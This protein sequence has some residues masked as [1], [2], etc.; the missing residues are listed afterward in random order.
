MT[1]YNEQKI[2]QINE[3]K[4]HPRNYRK[5]PDD[6]IEHICESIK[7]FGFYRNIVISEDNYILAGHGVVMAAKKLGMKEVPVIKVNY[8]HTDVSSL[9]IL[10]GDNE[11]SHLG[12]IDDRNLSEILRDILNT[13]V[14]KLLGTGYDENMLVNLV[15][16]S[17]HENEISDK[18]EAANW[19]GMPDY[20]DENKIYRLVVQFESEEKREEFIKKTEL[21]NVKK[22]T[23]AWSTWFPTKQD[24]D[25]S[26]VKIEEQ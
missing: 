15:Y 20:K 3:L 22:G 11:I 16:V 9:K 14:S 25:I 7:R 18:N 24:N 5:H 26:S 8:K 10:T 2:I 4:E 12:E 21:Q 1:T 19:V 13:D 6:Q 17:R 23:A